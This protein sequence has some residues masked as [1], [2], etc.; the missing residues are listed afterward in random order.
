MTH[1]EMIAVIQVH[2]DGKDI[3]S[4][5]KGGFRWV[6]ATNSVWNFELRTYRIKPAEPKKVKLLAYFTGSSLIR[7]T[8]DTD[9]PETWI[10]IP[11]EDKEIEVP[12]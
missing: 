8:A 10:R 12:A 4:C 3:E 6:R 5:Y 7:V 9:T 1:D 11:S 2:K